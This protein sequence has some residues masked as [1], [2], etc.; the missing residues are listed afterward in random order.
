MTTDRTL[1]CASTVSTLPLYRIRSAGSWRASSSAGDTRKSAAARSGPDLPWRIVRLHQRKSTV[2]VIADFAR[3]DKAACQT[4]ARKQEMN[5][6][7]AT[8][9]PDDLSAF[10]MPFTANRAFKVN[11]RMLA[12]AS[13][14]YYRTPEGREF[15]TA[16][17]ACGA[18]MRAIISRGLRKRS[19]SRRG[20]STTRRRSSL[21]I[22]CRSRW[23]AA[24]RG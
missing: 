13:G 3:R 2:F 9:V 4:A 20:R 6:S 10:W 23:P 16:L 8:A 21:G 15:S 14:M 24:W 12:S 7:A 19:S 22:R 17:P 11:P 5:V 1:S 18:S